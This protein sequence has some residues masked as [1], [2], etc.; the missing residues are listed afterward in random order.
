MPSDD[1]TVFVS[2]IGLDD[3]YMAQDGARRKIV[4]K[5]DE[6]GD[7][8]REFLLKMHRC[9][10]DVKLPNGEYSLYSIEIHAEIDAEGK[11]RVLGSGVGVGATGGIKFVLRR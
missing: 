2:D 3:E 11:L 8:V 5:L 6:F 9:F 7:D 4:R 10:K 1:V